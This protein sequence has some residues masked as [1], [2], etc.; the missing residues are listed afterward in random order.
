V[1]DTTIDILG[2]LCSFL[3]ILKKKKTPQLSFKVPPLI[4]HY[5]NP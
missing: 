3:K 1:R 5:W 4:N 2:K